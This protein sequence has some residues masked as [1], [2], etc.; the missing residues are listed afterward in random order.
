MGFLVAVLRV[1]RD[2]K[3]KVEV[4]EI[5]CSFSDYHGSHGKR[6]GLHK[7]QETGA[8]EFIECGKYRQ[9]QTQYQ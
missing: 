2:K 5:I 1:D 4:T 8:I 9:C 6:K 7:H 3:L